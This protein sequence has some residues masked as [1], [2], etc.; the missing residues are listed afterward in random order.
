VAPAGA[1]LI[2]GRCLKKRYTIVPLNKT[3]ASCLPKHK[4]D[5]AGQQTHGRATL[6]LEL[7]GY[8]HDVSVAMQYAFGTTFVCEDEHAARKVMESSD[9]KCRGVSLQGDDYNP[10]GTMTGGSRGNNASVL[11]R[12]EE[13][14]RVEEELERHGVQTIVSAW[15]MHAFWGRF[16]AFGGCVR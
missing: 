6:A 1:E 3:R 9:V 15:L 16:S 13:L 2:E 7:V 12:L 5:R 4:Q 8:D 11:A 10:S 14:N